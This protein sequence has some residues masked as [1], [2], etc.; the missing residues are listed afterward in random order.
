MKLMLET[1]FEDNLLL[2]EGHPATPDG[3]KR[4]RRGTR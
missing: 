3:E 4:A 2:G 1:R